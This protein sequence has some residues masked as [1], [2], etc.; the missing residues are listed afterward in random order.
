MHTVQGRGFRAQRSPLCPT[1][2]TG[3]GGTFCVRLGMYVSPRVKILGVGA[4]VKGAGCLL[5]TEPEERSP[6]LWSELKADA[7]IDH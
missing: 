3:V 4:R 6:L 2:P 7:A 5:H 1:H